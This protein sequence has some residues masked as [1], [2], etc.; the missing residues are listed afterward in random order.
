MK[1]KNIIQLNTI[2]LGG[3]TTKG[4]DC[5]ELDLSGYAKK[6]DVEKAISD[7]ITKTLT[8]EV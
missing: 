6:E 8:K 7:A 5:E 3:G 4:C 1:K 2:D